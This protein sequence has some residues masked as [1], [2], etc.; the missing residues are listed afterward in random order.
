MRDL[1]SRERELC[2]L[3]IKNRRS[4]NVTIDYKIST[5][6]VDILVFYSD[7]EDWNIKNGENDTNRLWKNLNLAFIGYKSKCLTLNYP[8]NGLYVTEY[9]FPMKHFNIDILRVSKISIRILK[10][11][12]LFILISLLLR[13]Q[14]FFIL[15]KPS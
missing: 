15:I 10:I 13:S 9:F 2:E 11:V 3:F 14:N 4:D 1:F 5:K 12:F 8:A 6:Y 7:K